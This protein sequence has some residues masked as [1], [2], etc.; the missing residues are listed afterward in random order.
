MNFV[1][2]A[3]KNLQTT[4]LG[5]APIGYGLYLIYRGFKSGDSSQMLTGIAALS[6]GAGLVAAKDGK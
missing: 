4:L 5:L 1:N 6:G 2:N 3:I